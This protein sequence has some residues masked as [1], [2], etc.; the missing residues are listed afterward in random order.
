[1]LNNKDTRHVCNNN[2]NKHNCTLE[3]SK[4]TNQY[5]HK[6]VTLKL[7]TA[8]TEV[9][10]MGFPQV[11]TILYSSLKMLTIVYNSN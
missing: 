10:F 4:K 2:Q 5:L 3:Q 9:K 1:M 11:P 6:P 8:L 7:V